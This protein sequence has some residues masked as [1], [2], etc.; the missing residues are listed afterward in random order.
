MHEVQ[1]QILKRV[2]FF[3]IAKRVVTMFI[4]SWISFIDYNSLDTILKSQ[5]CLSELIVGSFSFQSLNTDLFP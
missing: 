3:I 4:Y 1:E 5:Q 2:F